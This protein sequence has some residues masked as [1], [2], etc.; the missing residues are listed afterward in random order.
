MAHISE[1][2]EFTNLTKGKSGA[3]YKK[4]VLR[5]KWVRFMKERNESRKHYTKEETKLLFDWISNTA[6]K[7]T[8][9]SKIVAN[10]RRKHI[11]QNTTI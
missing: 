5:K 6:I 7:N 11:V 2:T 10:Y 8:D 4:A 1:K 3:M 9:L